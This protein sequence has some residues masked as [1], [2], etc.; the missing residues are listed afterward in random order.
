MTE[1]D[2]ELLPLGSSPISEDAPCGESV[3]YE[4]EFEQL[5][6][7]L[8]KL[9]SLKGEPVDWRTVVQLSSDILRSK[10]KDLLVAVYL[11]QGLLQTEGYRGLA[12][13]LQIISDMVEKFW[14]DMF[15]AKKRLRARKVAMEWLAEKAS[16]YIEEKAPGD[17]DAVAVL[18]AARLSR[19]LDG[20]L[21]EKMEDNAPNM[22]ELTRPMK[23]FRETFKHLEQQ[24][25]AAQPEVAPQPEAAPQPSATLEPA[26]PAPAQNAAPAPKPEPAPE[27]AQAPAAESEPKIDHELTPLGATPVSDT[28]PCGES[29]RYEPEFEQL[30]GE[31]AKL[32]SLNGAPV[33]WRTVVQLS[34]DILGSKSKD[35]LV[36]VYLTQGL[37]QTEGYRGLAV[38][39]QIMSDM[40]EKYWD[41]MFPAKKRLRARK[42]AMEWFAE[43][44]GQYIEENPPGDADADAILVAAKL[45]RELDGDLAEKME[46]NA[47]NMVDLTRSMKRFRESFKQQQQ[48]QKQA[49]QQ[50][51]AAEKPAQPEPAPQPEAAA[52][53]APAAEPAPVQQEAAAPTPPPAPK[54]AAKVA[55]A[56]EIAA[57]S[58]D[59][60]SD[61]E[62]RKALRQLQDG[63]RKIGGFFT[64]AK[65]SDPRGYRLGRTAVWMTI[66][67]LP[68]N[69]DG[70]TQLPAPPAERRKHFD[71]LFEQAQ[72]SALIPDAE[73][74]VAR[75]AFWLDGQRLVAGSLKAMG[76]EYAA[77]HQTV[78]SE[79]RSFLERVP[80]VTDLKFSDGTPFAD[81]ATRMWIETEVT[82]ASSSGASG[83]GQSSS[84]PAPWRDSLEEAR[85]MAAAGKIDKAVQQMHLGISQ[86]PT[87]REKFYWR[88]A[89]AEL[90]VQSGNL[91]VAIG[92]LEQMAE[93]IER[94]QLDQ[95]E[96]EL[97]VPIYQRLLEAYRKAAKPTK[98]DK[99]A[100]AVDAGLQEKID[101]VYSR[102]CWL[103]PATAITV[104]GD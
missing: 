77:A 34:S 28:A 33:D 31:V 35:L 84:G 55:K 80:G 88:S 71:S 62:A 75:S 86:A 1:L 18:M 68:P 53:Q 9:E 85:G 36:A 91:D 89:L 29:V 51:P 92:M 19:E 74:L 7:E 46:D 96:S 61:S 87:D 83:S 40:V 100:A 98:K 20:D 103:D 13:G 44:A 37:L 8:S 70:V 16:R 11:S 94:L 64:K 58:G 10:S 69:K 22:V 24:Q 12:V 66:D 23:R 47:P 41:D 67:K 42:V 15:P 97:V 25:A 32:E 27:P 30:E 63:V 39:L 5:E 4:P 78:I 60:G 45:S 52:Q 56:P 14:D 59:V 21:A 90:L 57:P 72:F 17:A 65:L 49:A 26:Q 81:D 38:G 73:Q 3:R 50:A 102:L 48:Q 101:S 99:G 79:L 82:S 54:P 95:W 2:H 104:K 6:G 93:R 76:A 43:K